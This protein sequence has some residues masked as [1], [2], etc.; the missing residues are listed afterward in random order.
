MLIKPAATI[1]HPDRVIASQYRMDTTKPGDSCRANALIAKQHGR[2][3]HER[4]FKTLEILIE[5][6]SAQSNSPDRQKRVLGSPG[7]KLARNLLF[8]FICFMQASTNRY[9]RSYAELSLE[10]DVQILAMASIFILHCEH[11]LQEAQSMLSIGSPLRSSQRFATRYNPD[12]GQT[13]RICPNT[14]KPPEGGAV[15]FYL[16]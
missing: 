5:G 12:D 10:K 3:D 13:P 2:Y 1:G 15:I 11:M 4:V 6:C 14:T 8:R 9:L 7:T 16:T